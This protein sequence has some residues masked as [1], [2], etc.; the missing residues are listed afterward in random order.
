MRKRQIAERD[1][2]KNRI[3]L[4]DLSD[5]L[6]SEEASVASSEDI[7]TMLRRFKELLDELGT[8]DG[9]ILLQDH[10]ALWHEKSGSLDQAVAHRLREIELL[11]RLFEISPLNKLVVPLTRR[12]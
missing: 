4:N 9:S 6:H 10:W 2:I 5:L 8:D 1:R 3:E 12:F 7:A 11:C